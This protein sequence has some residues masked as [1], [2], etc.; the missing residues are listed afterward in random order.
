MLWIY[1]SVFLIQ[2]VGF[3]HSAFLI[4]SERY[5]DVFGCGTFVLVGLL[6]L[7]KNYYYEIEHIGESGY[8]YGLRRALIVSIFIIVWSSRLVIFLNDR[9]KRNKKDK[10]FDK[11]RNNPKKFFIYWFMQS[12]WINFTITPLLLVTHQHFSISLSLIDYILIL[13][14]STFFTIEAVA[15]GQKTLFLGKPEN[16]GKFIN[17][18]LWKRL[19]RH[20]NYFSEIMMHWIIYFICFRGLDSY[21]YKFISLISP[22]FT[23]FLMLKISTPMMEKISDEK[24][25]GN[26]QYQEYKKST[27][28]IIP[29]IN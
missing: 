13:L 22:L 11:V 12:L 18:G 24:F 5:Y 8:V 19:C 21:W 9:I 1:L 14:W 16:K 25:S 29:F 15:D 28:K 17:Q 2:F 10:R 6:S 7:V 3:L 27:Y 20:P 23:S 26:P 4:K